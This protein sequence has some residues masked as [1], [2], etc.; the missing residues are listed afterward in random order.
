M[1]G[2]HHLLNGCE[3]EQTPGDGDGQGSLMCCS[4]WRCKQSDM[5]ER[6]NNNNRRCS[7]NHSSD[8]FGKLNVLLPS[9]DKDQRLRKTAFL[10]AALVS[11]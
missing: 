3:F 2:W 1:V 9:F 4:R 11:T 8:L 7:S 5:T 6:L 10:T